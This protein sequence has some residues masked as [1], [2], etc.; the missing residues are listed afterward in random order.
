MVHQTVKVLHRKQV[1]SLFLKLDVAKAFDSLAGGAR[2]QRFWC[3]VE[4][5]DLFDVGIHEGDAQWLVGQF[6]IAMIINSAGRGVACR[7][8]PN[9]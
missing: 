3:E 6:T 2:P 5:L 7:G 4:I 1:P 9:T 8:R